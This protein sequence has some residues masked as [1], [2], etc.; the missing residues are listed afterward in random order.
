M[1]IFIEKLFLYI[2][3]VTLLF[4][5]VTAVFADGF[6]EFNDEDKHR[7]EKDKEDEEDHDPWLNP[8][9]FMHFAF[10]FMSQVV[11]YNFYI[12]NT[13]NE[14][15]AEAAAFATSVGIGAL[16]E[17]TDRVFSWRDM[18]INAAGAATGIAVRFEF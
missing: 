10:G 5:S 1:N 17:S 15:L 8:D 14:G 16:K 12:R 2:L 13:D 6:N 9:K 18:A 7:I 11:F 4:S 3:I